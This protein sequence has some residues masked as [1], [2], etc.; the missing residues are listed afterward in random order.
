MIQIIK[1][2]GHEEGNRKAHELLKVH[3]SKKSLLVMCGGI[4]TD[5][6]AM[7]VVP[8]DLLIGAACVGDERYGEQFHMHSNELLI[9][10]FGVLS[11][12]EKKGIEFYKIL[13]GQDVHSTAKQYN[14]I[15]TALLSRFGERVGVMGIGADA[16]TAGIF[17]QSLATHSPDYVVEEAV[18]NEFSERI[19][20]T[21]KALGEFTTFV[22]LAFGEKKVQA[23][24][25]VLDE[26]ETDLYKYPAV[27]YRTSPIRSYLITDADV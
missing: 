22:I 27:F 24:R 20:M 17:P 18:D 21:L 9:K 8:N 19:T 3:L 12:F 11:Y 5:Y 6:R 26:T 16:H 14:L 4:Y 2:S 15:A 7:I 10:N 1:V 25:T 23:I 13:N